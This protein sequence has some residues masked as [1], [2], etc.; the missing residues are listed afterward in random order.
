[1]EILIASL[2][3]NLV[4]KF[5]KPEPD[6]DFDI[7]EDSRRAIIRVINAVLG[8]VALVV[9]SA[10]MGTELDTSSLQ[11]LFETVV[12]VGITFLTSQ[13]AYLLGKK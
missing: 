3:A 10:V 7:D 4:T 11:G 9:T 6:S 1:M 2:L 5:F 8:I 13:G 12:A